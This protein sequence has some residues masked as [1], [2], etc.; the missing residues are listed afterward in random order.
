MGR[1]Q[2][3]DRH[4]NGD[5]VIKLSESSS[6]SFSSDLITLINRLLNIWE[7]QTM[8]VLGKIVQIEKL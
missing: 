2:K 1:Y 8:F 4:E 6:E 5:Y 3:R 7:E